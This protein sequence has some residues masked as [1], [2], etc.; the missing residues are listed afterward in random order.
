MH[1]SVLYEASI[2]ALNIKKD[3]IYIDATLG[4]AGHTQAILEKLTKNTI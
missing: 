1:I 2:E 3:G 4:R